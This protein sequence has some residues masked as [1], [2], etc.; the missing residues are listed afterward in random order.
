MA[1]NRATSA[2]NGHARRGQRRGL[3]FLEVVC[4]VGLLAV[5]VASVVSAV[6]FI[7]NSQHTQQRKL[8]ATEVANRLMLIY[9]DDP[10]ELKR[11]GPLVAYDKLKY[12]WQI[13]EGNVGLRSIKSGG[14]QGSTNSLNRF[15]N[16]TLVTWLSEESGGAIE[17]EPGVPIGRVTRMVDPVPLRNPDSLRNAVQNDDGRTRLIESFIGGGARPRGTGRPSGTGTGSGSKPSGSGSGSGSSGA[18]GGK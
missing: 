18:G 15:T 4:A 6:T 16:V 2:S 7:V 12:R 13:R 1:P 3:T 11:M 8:N 17:P 10:N 9:L 5:V 14:V